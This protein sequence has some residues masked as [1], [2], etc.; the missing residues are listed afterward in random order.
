MKL[1]IQIIMRVDIFN[2]ADSH[3]ENWMSSFI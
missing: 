3:L 2:A 1:K